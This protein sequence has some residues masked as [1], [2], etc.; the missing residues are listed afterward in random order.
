MQ[1]MQDACV[2]FKDEG[3][4]GSL[5]RLGSYAFRIAT[6]L[7]FM[8]RLENRNV[9]PVMECDCRDFNNALII[10]KTL[11]L[12]CMK[13]YGGIIASASSQS[14]QLNAVG[15]RADKQALFDALPATFTRQQFDEASKDIPQSPRTIEGWLYRWNKV[16]KVKQVAYATY[17]K[18]V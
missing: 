2:A 14:L 17:Q 3:V 8:R 4:I 13:L 1:V 18:V 7:T 12:H 16:G 9:E 6:G 5:H 10:V 11:L 15:E